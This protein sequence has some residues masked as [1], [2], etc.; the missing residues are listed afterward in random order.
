MILFENRVFFEMT[1][2]S[3]FDAFISLCSIVGLRHHQRYDRKYNNYCQQKHFY[4]SHL[5][6]AAYLV[7]VLIISRN[8][9]KFSVLNIL[10]GPLF[11][12]LAVLVH[13]VVT[14]LSFHISSC[15]SVSDILKLRQLSV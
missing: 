14:K 5:R 4:G 6:S 11:L 7:H 1:L 3:L 12:N 8:Y 2:Q 15:P 10:K 9:G 13:C